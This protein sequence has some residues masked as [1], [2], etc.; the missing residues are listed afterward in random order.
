VNAH[1]LGTLLL[2]VAFLAIVAAAASIIPTRRAVQI[3]P[4]IALR[5]E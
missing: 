2:S 5:S 1:D 3:D 4:A